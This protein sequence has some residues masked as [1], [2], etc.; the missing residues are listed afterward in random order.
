MPTY[1]LQER[2]PE[3]LSVKDM[4]SDAIKYLGDNNEVFQFKKME[5]RSKI[6]QGAYFISKKFGHRSTYPDLYVWM[7][8]IDRSLGGHYIHFEPAPNAQFYFQVVL[9]GKESNTGNR[10]KGHV[11]HANS[12][13][14]DQKSGISI[15]DIEVSGFDV[16]VDMMSTSKISTGCKQKLA[17]KIREK[18]GGFSVNHIGSAYHQGGI[19]TTDIDKDKY[20]E[21]LEFEVLR[22][23]NGVVKWSSSGWDSQDYMRIR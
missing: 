18:W 8:N 16:L 3:Y 21:G 13:I 20:R 10:L 15:L 9:L 1:H 22:K 14:F 19:T 7:P 11:H 4:F 23:K 6:K 17:A 5:K 12:V 2:I